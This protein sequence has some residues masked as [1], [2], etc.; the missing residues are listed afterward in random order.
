MPARSVDHPVT[1][2]IAIFFN[3][4][5]LSTDKDIS[6]V[7]LNFTATGVNGAAITSES[8]LEVSLQAY[9][10]NGLPINLKDLL[11]VQK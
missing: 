3:H 4:I 6:G 7:R 1:T 11:N 10:P 2:I 9:V 5:D 8:T